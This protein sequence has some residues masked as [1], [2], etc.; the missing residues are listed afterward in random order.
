MNILQMNRQKDS[1]EVSLTET[2]FKTCCY[3]P[4]GS[5]DDSTRGVKSCIPSLGGKWFCCE[6]CC[7]MYKHEDHIT[8]NLSDDLYRDMLNRVYKID[9]VC[10]HKFQEE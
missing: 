1:D 10:S 6:L 8:T 7:N 3:R 9:N 5:L 2:R 4:C